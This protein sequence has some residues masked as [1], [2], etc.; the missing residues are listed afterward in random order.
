MN[1]EV[2]DLLVE[3]GTEELPPRALIALSD[4]LVDG[5]CGGLNAAGIDFG[6]PTPFATPRR[7]AVLLRDVALSQPDRETER[8]G[9][10]VEACFNDGQPTPALEGFARS[11]GVAPDDLDREQTDKGERMLFRS[12][13][14]GAATAELLPEILEKAVSGLPIPKRM[15]WG[16]GEAEFVRPV[17]WLVV[18]LGEAVV[19]M[20]L[21][22]LDADRITYGH[23]FHA[24]EA[25]ELEYPEDY[26]AELGEAHVMADFNERRSRIQVQVQQAATEAGGQALL[27]EDLLDEVTALVEWPIAVTGSF[28]ERFLKLPREVLIAVMRDH[29]RY[30]AIEAADDQL[31]PAFVTVSNIESTEPDN[32]VRGNER[33]IRPRF[34]DA[35]FFWEQDLARPLAAYADGL[36]SI[37][38]QKE[39]GTIADRSK[40]IESIS[41]Y[42]AQD[43]GYDTKATSR[44]ARLAKADLL[45]QM[46][47]EFTEL[48][49]VMGRYYAIESGEPEA[50]AQGIEEQYLPRHAG[51]RLPES[52]A[53]IA[54]AIGDKLDLIA[55]IVAIGKRPTGNRDP[56]GLR[57]AAI[58]ILRILIEKHI[59]VDL[60]RLMARA[61]SVQPLAPANSQEG[62][63]WD[64]MRDRLQSHLALEHDKL[65]IAAAVAVDASR[66][67]DL[68]KRVA[69]LEEF[70]ESEDAPALC[71][72]HKRATNILRKTETDAG[73]IDESLLSEPAE[74]V[75]AALI[76]SVSG[77][78]DEALAD[79]DY[80]AALSAM[81]RLREPVDEFFDEVMV[82]AED[83]ALRDNRIALLGSLDRLFGRVAD[84][85]LVSAS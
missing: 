61:V 57:R 13:E 79:A 81:A 68:K 56:F 84:L 38:H 69:A 27:D 71:A 34:E 40:R 1:A 59:D 62:D 67:C 6:E 36:G 48:Q 85:G 39:L 26:E 64:F 4:A 2:T 70:L 29:Q 21:L 72:A 16:S 30:F 25:I 80:L 58:G 46:V 11:C 12:T 23:R 28:D 52:E 47:Y 49:G 14:P 20:R 54:L 18:L 15:R 76:E 7:L 60:Q 73:Q 3:I 37:T 82:M 43:V 42:F 44:A 33:V 75:L 32:I 31:L 55:G 50:V 63:A 74:K 35:L 78:V 5:L 17:H 24:P 22:G 8:L 41:L 9:P 65:A 77:K 53:G 83:P 10:M 66:P 45:S 19:P 51:D